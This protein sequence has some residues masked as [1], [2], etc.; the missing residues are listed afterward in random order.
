MY[1]FHIQGTDT[2]KLKSTI[3]RPEVSTT[4]TLNPNSGNVCLFWRRI[5]ASPPRHTHHS[6][7]CRS[8]NPP[9]DTSSAL[10]CLFSA[11]FITITRTKKKQLQAA[12]CPLTS[13]IMCFAA[14][15]LYLGLPDVLKR[16][17]KPTDA[18]TGGIKWT[19]EF[20]RTEKTDESPP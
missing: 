11:F 19:L 10:F 18:C 4:P 13:Q 9:T 6:A 15:F 12:K 3:T 1:L 7:G 16:C 14:G 2:L 8:H 5:E 17:Q 20:M